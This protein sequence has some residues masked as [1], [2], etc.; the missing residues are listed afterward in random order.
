L[1]SLDT[2]IGLLPSEK[3]VI[4]EEVKNKILGKPGEF[5]SESCFFKRKLTK[6]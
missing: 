5:A 6:A 2:V 4:I 3:S 1:L